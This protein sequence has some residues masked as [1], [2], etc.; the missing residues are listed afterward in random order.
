MKP[1]YY[2]RPIQVELKY[3][4]LEEQDKRKA[5]RKNGIEYSHGQLEMDKAIFQGLLPELL[6]NLDKGKNGV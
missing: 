4:V 5:F 1:S 2:R 3:D 6:K